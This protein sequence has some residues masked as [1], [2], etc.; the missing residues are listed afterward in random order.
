MFRIYPRIR[1]NEKP[2][3]A[4]W[5]HTYVRELASIQ[6]YACIPLWLKN[7]KLEASVCLDQDL[8]YSTQICNQHRNYMELRVQFFTVYT[9]EWIMFNL[10]YPIQSW[11]VWC[12]EVR[13]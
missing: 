3:T 1:R 5:I 12:K 6:K 2:R 13:A 8:F 11:S 10:C 4:F 9:M 7:N